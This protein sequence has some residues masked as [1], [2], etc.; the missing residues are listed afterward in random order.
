MKSLTRR[1]WE[2]LYYDGLIDVEYEVFDE[3]SQKISNVRKGYSDGCWGKSRADEKKEKYIENKY[4]EYL[5]EMK[6]GDVKRIR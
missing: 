4:I 2:D 1:N 6:R 5:L 3:E